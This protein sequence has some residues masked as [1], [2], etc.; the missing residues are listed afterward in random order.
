[1]R[2]QVAAFIRHGDIHGLAD[3]SGF[4]FSGGNDAAGVFESNGGLS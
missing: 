1:V 4:L 2:D 3:F